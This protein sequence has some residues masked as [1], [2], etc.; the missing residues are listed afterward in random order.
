MSHSFDVVKDKLEEIR[1]GDCDPYKISHAISRMAQ[2]LMDD[3]EDK[4]IHTK[5]GMALSLLS[6]A[7]GQPIAS[8]RRTAVVAALRALNRE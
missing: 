5:L 8:H 2:A 3:R 7:I 6:P 1:E 4:I